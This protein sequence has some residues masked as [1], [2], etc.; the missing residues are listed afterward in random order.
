MPP[1]RASLSRPLMQGL[2][3]SAAVL[4][5]K[6]GAPPRQDDCPPSPPEPER[7][8]IGKLLLL[9]ALALTA[10][11]G[12]GVWYSVQRAEEQVAWA[13]QLTG[14]DPARAPA[15]IIANG[16][17]GCHTVPGVPGARGTVGPA[18]EG[19]AERA[20]V[21]GVLPNTPENLVRWISHS[22]DVDPETAMPNTFV[23]E[24]DARDIAALLYSIPG[25][26]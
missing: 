19:L 11:V 16:C 20:F 9:L 5:G 13:R 22:R 4:L 8:R 7:L 23:S 14:G 24:Q 3:L 10:T 1:R 17:G 15:L 26:E 2:V 12:F 25:P 21:G 18:L 6:L